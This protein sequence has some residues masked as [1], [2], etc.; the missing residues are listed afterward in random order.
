MQCFKLVL[1]IQIIISLTHKYRICICNWT[2][3]YLYYKYQVCYYRLTCVYL[4]I[5]L[6][7]KNF[8]ILMHIF[9]IFSSL[10]LVCFVVTA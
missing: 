9:F 4:K 7:G 3:T 2:F 6:C 5:G 8:L 1:P 10:F